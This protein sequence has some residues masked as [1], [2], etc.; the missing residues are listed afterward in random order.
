MAIPEHLMIIEY[1]ISNNILAI[2]EDMVA[3]FNSTV[4]S[5]E[6]VRNFIGRDCIEADSRVSILTREQYDNL[7]DKVV[8]SAED[9]RAFYADLAMEQKETM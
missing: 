8:L 6:E 1:T 3:L 2:E 5:E 4:I 9:D 7:F